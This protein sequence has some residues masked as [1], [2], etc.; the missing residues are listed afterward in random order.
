MSIPL[1]PASCRSRPKQAI[2]LTMTYIVRFPEGPVNVLGSCPRAAEV[3]KYNNPK[4][5]LKMAPKIQ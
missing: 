4:L 3:S 1:S 2:G 5:L